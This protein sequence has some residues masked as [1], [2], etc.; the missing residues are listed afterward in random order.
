MARRLIPV[1]LLVP[2]LLLAAD[3]WLA[4]PD[5][6][7]FDPGAM[8]RA[9]AALWRDYYDGRWVPLGMRMA[10]L[11]RR[12]YGFSWWDSVRASFHAARAALHFRRRTDDPRCLPALAAYYDILAP[13]MPAGF[14]AA[15]AADLE[16]RWWTERRRDVPEAEYAGTIAALAAMCHG[17]TAAAAEPAARLRADTMAYRDARSGRMTGKDWDHVAARLGE[18]WTAMRG[19][20]DAR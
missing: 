15:Q 16:L 6:T 10:A 5:M 17:V 11:A 1:L 19:A 3:H 20:V 9:E 14:S 2:A 18:A 13:A 12:Q 4:R 8:G 7:R